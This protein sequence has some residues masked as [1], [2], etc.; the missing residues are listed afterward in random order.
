MLTFSTTCVA[1]VPPLPNS[2]CHSSLL[3]QWVQLLTSRL[4][5]SWPSCLKAAETQSPSSD[6]RTASFPVSSSKTTVSSSDLAVGTV[7]RG[8]NAKFRLSGGKDKHA[9]GRQL[10][11]CLAGPSINHPDLFSTAHAKPFSIRAEG[12][13]GIGPR[14]DR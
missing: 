10:V 2:L 14:V 8:M 1:D 9:A 5:R 3:L 6:R 4:A 7:G 13:F 12:Q 11:P